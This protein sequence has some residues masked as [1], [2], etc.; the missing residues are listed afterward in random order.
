[1]EDHLKTD[2]LTNIVR[3]KMM[4]IENG[5]CASVFWTENGMGG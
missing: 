3:S 4:Y 1:M 2:W 5:F